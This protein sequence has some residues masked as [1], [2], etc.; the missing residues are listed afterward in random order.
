[1]ADPRHDS[2]PNYTRPALGMRM[3]KLICRHCK[4]EVESRSSF[5]PKHLGEEHASWCP[6]KRLYG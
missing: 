4:V 1:M 2:T 5:Y 3:T 6:R